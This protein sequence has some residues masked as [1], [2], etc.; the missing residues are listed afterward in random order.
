MY[1]ARAATELKR[2]KSRKA[3]TES[4]IRFHEEAWPQIDPADFSGNWH[5]D[6]IAEHL[7]AVACGQIKRLL[8]N[9]P[10]RCSKS[11]L[12]AV[13]FPAWVW[14]QERAA[15]FPLSGP[16]VQ[17]LF[18]SYSQVLSQRDSLK[19]RRLLASPWYRDRWGGN[20]SVRSDKDTERKFENDKGGYRLAT[21]VGGTLTGEGGDCLIIDDALNS[22]QAN[23]EAMRQAANDW[24]DESMSSRLNNQN[25]G[26]KI[27]VMQRLH[28]DDLAGHILDRAQDEEWDSL[29]IPMEYDGAW[30]KPTSIGWVDPRAEDGEL[31]W[32]DRFSRVAVDRLKRDLGPYASAGQL[33]Q[34][35]APKSGGIILR[36]WWQLWPAP[37]YEPKDG[38]PLVYPPC[39]LI[40]GSVDTAY[41][42]KDEGAWNAM[43]VWGVWAD[44]RQRPKVVMMEAWRARL[45]LRGVFPEGCNTE[46]ERKP[47]WGLADKI[48]DTVRRRNISVLVIEN[49]TRAT[50]LAAELRRLLRDGECM[51]VL[52]NPVGDKV[53][54]MHAVQSMFA[55][56]MVHAPDKAWA[57]TVITEIA[58]FPK[59]KWKDYADTASQAL[60]WL[61]NNNILLL[62]TEA[63]TENR[64]ANLFQS[65]REPAY[66]V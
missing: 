24:W 13:S 64:R 29:I 10:P 57:D 27:V 25:W 52:E 14:A 39:S 62:G 50:D 7:E 4:L 2:R 17:F 3:C 31:L 6:A 54:R 49:K 21:S 43:T 19:M 55:D 56:G 42:E 15:G 40:V 34:L 26:A 16:Q 63:D 12:V 20:F 11:S 36:D 22:L 30:R 51:I 32:P 8:I 66:D 46:E 38:E 33:Q 47:H 1:A 9:I 18:A 45:P 53:A 23:Y 60:S 35:P 58:Q 59:S 48:A 28:E 61:R 37:G 5:L 65:R 44:K 41:S